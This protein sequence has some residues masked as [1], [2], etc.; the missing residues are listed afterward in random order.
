MSDYDKEQQS[1]LVNYHARLAMGVPLDGESLQPKGQ[2]TNS[3]IKSEPKGGLA[4]AN[5]K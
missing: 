1:E 2:K 5:E 4:Q 3:D